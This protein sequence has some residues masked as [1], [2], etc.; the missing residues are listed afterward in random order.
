MFLKL[1]VAI[2]ITL[3]AFFMSH[4]SFAQQWSLDSCL[5]Y[6][7]ENNRDLLANKQSIKSSEYALKSTSLQL[8][9]EIDGMT[10]IDHYWQIP[11]QVFPGELLGQP[12]GSF[13]PVRLGTPW[14]GNLGLEARLKLVDPQSWQDIKL[15]TLQHQAS[16]SQFISL[17]KILVKN[18]TMAYFQ[19]QQHYLNVDIANRH[20]NNYQEI[21]RLIV[22]QFEKG[23]SDKITFNQSL[24]LLKDRENA[25]AQ[26]KL[27][28]QSAL[29]DL[30][31][32]MGY[33]LSEPIMIEGK[34]ELNPTEIGTDFNPSFLPDYSFQKLQVE[35]AEQQYKASL[36]QCFPSLYLSSGFQRLGFGQ[37]IDFLGQSQWFSSGFVS[38]D[39]RIP[40]LSLRNMVYNPRKQKSEVKIATLQFE[41][42][43]KEQEKI[44]LQTNMKMEEAWKSVLLQRENIQLAEENEKLSQQKIEKGIIDMI[45]LKQIQQD[46]NLAQEKLS[47]AELNFLGY[48]V[49]MKYIQSN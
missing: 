1:K 4:T 35:T 6:S 9:P 44:Y 10:G 27:A 18:V 46:L 41:N 24:G 47:T 15:A 19:A 13:V 17:Q 2:T 33:P 22:L 38:L 32:W 20:Y 23:L 3:V 5:R 43:L 7:W 25:L 16:K 29:I 49:E 42:Y 40:L 14:M 45:Q 21:H 36:S 37:T 28:Y 8:A 39:V 12:E 48:L 11:V 30:K 26:S 34:K 31:F